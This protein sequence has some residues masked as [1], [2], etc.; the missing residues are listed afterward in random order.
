MEKTIKTFEEF[1]D[2]VQKVAGDRY[3]AV[4]MEKTTYHDD[5]QNPREFRYEYKCYVDGFSWHTDET[6]EDAIH[7]LKKQMRLIKDGQEG[8]EAE[9]K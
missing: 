1:S 6:P 2:A 8:L 7:E 9:I 5:Y 3:F 4:A